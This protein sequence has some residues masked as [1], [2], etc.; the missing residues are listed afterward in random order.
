M[1]ATISRALVFVAVVVVQI[2]AASGAQAQLPGAPSC[3]PA[4]IS[5]TPRDGQRLTARRG[6]C[7]GVSPSVTL[8]WFLCDAQ[9]ESCT[10]RTRQIEAS[11]LTYTVGGADVNGRLVVQQVAQNA[12]GSDLDDTPTEVVA[13]VPPSATPDISGVAQVGEEL[14]GTEGFL[15]GTNPSLV[16]LQWLRCD[17]DGTACVEIAGATLAEYVL[18]G[19]DAGKTVRFQVTVEGPQHIVDVQSPPTSV[20]QGQVL[21]PPTTEP[22]PAPPAPKVRLM[23]PFPS[24]LIAGRVFSSSAVV[25]RL[26]VRGPRGARVIVTCRGRDCPFRRRR[27]RI[28][29]RPL[30][31]RSLETDLAA[32]TVIRIR[33]TSPGRIGKFTRL[34]IL[35]DRPPARTDRC[36]RPGRRRPVPCPGGVG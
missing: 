7:S 11:S 30:R 34:R 28:R 21:P 19:D 23:R 5:G 35:G 8:Q 20:V 32:G 9:L 15:S 14:I 2:M 29:A 25:S 36:L 1:T 16:G 27:G 12:I 26:Q 33:V 13:A 17:A 31:L 22:P 6:D 10:S 18:T 3:D 4:T 24:I